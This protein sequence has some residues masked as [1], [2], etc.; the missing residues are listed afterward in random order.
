MVEELI[1]KKKQS[2]K[3]PDMAPLAQAEYEAHPENYQSPEQVHARHILVS[4]DEKTKAEKLK[5]MQSLKKR[6]AKGEDFAEL[7]KQYSEDKGSSVKGGDLG[8]FSKGQMVKPFEDAAFALQKPK[9]LSDIFESK[10]GWHLIQLE[11]KIPARIKPFA[12][13]KAGMIASLEQDYMKN[14]MKAWR[15]AIIDPKKS[16]LN[17]PELEKVIQEIKKLP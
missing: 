11:E 10:F 7:A 4:F 5:F 16:T 3:I 12:E 8:V 13:V 9:Q 2:I 6:A 15:D 1:A 17:E 14:E